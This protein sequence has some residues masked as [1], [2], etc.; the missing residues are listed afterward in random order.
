MSY[1]QVT[2]KGVSREM[3]PDEKAYY[4]EAHSLDGVVEYQK[5]ILNFECERVIKSGFVSS[6]LGTPHTYPTKTEDQRNLSD[7][8]LGGVGGPFDADDGNGQ[9]MIA[10]TAAQIDQVWSDGKDFKIAMIT[11]CK[12]LKAQVDTIAAGEG[13]VEE[14]VAAIEA[15]VWTDPV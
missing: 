15:V 7:L 2:Y 8:K 6:A 5:R 4:D 9:Q 12:T 13:T 14:K 1:P 10:H 3:T 11:Q